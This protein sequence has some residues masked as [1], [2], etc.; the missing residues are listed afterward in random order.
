MT[1]PPRTSGRGGLLEWRVLV[2]LGHAVPLLVRLRRDHQLHGDVR[3]GEPGHAEG[4][5]LTTLAIVILLTRPMAGRLGDRFGY[6]R[7]FV[8]CLVLITAGLTCLAIGGSQ[9]LADRVGDPVRPGFGTAYPVYVGYVMRRRQ[10]RAPRRRVRRDPRRFRYRRRHGLDEHGLAH[11]AP[12]LPVRLRRGRGA[13][14]ARPALF[15]HDG[16]SSQDRADGITD[17]QSRIVESLNRTACPR[18]P[19]RAKEPV[20]IIRARPLQNYSCGFRL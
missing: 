1:P 13:F 19:G 3:R 7:V 18:R 2:D 17:H 9:P 8:P 16:Q 12:R 6:K 20:T 14:G 15:P 11:P 10:R 4:I 5:Y